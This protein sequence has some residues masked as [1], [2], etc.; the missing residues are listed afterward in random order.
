MRSMALPGQAAAINP[1]VAY[2]SAKIA[3]I[4]IFLLAFFFQSCKAP[5]RSSS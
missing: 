5:A 4:D 1:I 2:P 3:I